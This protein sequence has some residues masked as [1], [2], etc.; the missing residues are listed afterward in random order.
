ME[1]CNNENPLHE[2]NQSAASDRSLKTSASRATR[3]SPN[4]GKKNAESIAAMLEQES[5]QNRTSTMRI[6]RSDRAAA[7]RRGVVSTRANCMFGPR[8]M[9]HSR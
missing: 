8:A 5:N 9:P 4:T 7:C 1:I 2:S 6:A 3:T